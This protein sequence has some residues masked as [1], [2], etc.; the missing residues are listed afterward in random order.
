M[1]GSYASK[2]IDLREKAEIVL[3]TIVLLDKNYGISYLVRIVR[4]NDEFPLKQ[5]E[6]KELETFGTMEK[7]HSER[8]KNLIFYLIDCDLLTITNREYGIVGITTKGKSFL[9]SQE[10]L[11]APSDTLQT[12][13]LENL[14]SKE[15]KNLRKRVAEE[16]GIKI[17]EV[18]TDYTLQCILRSKPANKADLANLPGMGNLNV[19]KYGDHIMEAIQEAGNKKEIQALEDAEKKLYSPSYQAVKSLF[20]AGLS[21]PEIAQSREVK[22]N[23]VSTILFDLHKGGEIDLIPWIEQE[24]DQET[25][26]KG[27]EYFRNSQERRLLPAFEKLGLDYETLRMCRLYV[28]QVY[29]VE[30]E[31]QVS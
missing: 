9:E 19:E 10:P 7:I 2:N 13:L 24:L 14:L 16:K 25:L 20:Q 11:I 6:H 26:E 31:I 27:V 1:A 12:H 28:D 3:K 17:Y 18:F 21:I 8:I 5:E 22:P 4:G 15:L 29:T 23:T 30:E